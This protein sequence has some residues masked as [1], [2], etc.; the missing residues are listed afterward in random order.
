MS[1]A[2]LT[3]A[4][5]TL[6]IVYSIL[7]E[8]HWPVVRDFVNILDKGNWGLFGIYSMALFILSLLL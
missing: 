1:E 7:Y 2:W 3:I 6:A 5:F 4:V 8:G